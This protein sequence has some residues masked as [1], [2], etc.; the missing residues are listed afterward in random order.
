MRQSSRSDWRHVRTVGSRGPASRWRRAGT[1]AG[2]FALAA[3]A[4]LSATP[5]GAELSGVGFTS[6]LEGGTNGC[7]LSAGGTLY[8]WGSNSHDQLLEANPSETAPVALDLSA[9]LG[10]NSIT[11]YAT[12]NGTTCVLSSASAVYC[13]GYNGQGELGDGS[14]GGT[15]PA[16]PVRVSFSG[17]QSGTITQLVG[18]GDKTFCA[19]TST[20]QIWCWG[21]G[22]QGQLG[23]DASPTNADSPVQVYTGGVLSGR[24]I[25]SISGTTDV[26]CA[27]DTG[28]GAYCW[29]DNSDDALG[30]GSSASTTQPV[31]V[32][33]AAFPLGDKVHAIAP[34][35][36][37][38]CLVDTNHAVWCWG[39]NIGGVN[40]LGDPDGTGDAN[41]WFAVPQ[42]V[43]TGTSALTGVSASS[44]VSSNTESCGLSAAGALYCWGADPIGDGGSDADVLSPEAITGGDIVGRTLVRVSAASYATCAIDSQSSLYCW[45][46]NNSGEIGDGSTV[47]SVTAEEIAASPSAT[48][49]ASVPNT[50]REVA[51]EP[52]NDSMDVTWSAPYSN[53]GSSVTGFTA[54]ATTLDGQQSF[55]C[56]AGA[57]DTGCTIDGLANGTSYDLSVVA[58]N[59]HGD[60]VP[61]SAGVVTLHTVP[62]APSLESVS[63]ASGEIIVTWLEGG[64]DGGLSVESFTATATTSTTSQ[65]CQG[66]PDAT[67]CTIEGLVD[68]T[69]YDVSV[70]AT[71][72]DGNSMPSNTLSAT[73]GTVS[74]APQGV[75]ASAGPASVQVSWSAPASDGDTPI[76]GYVAT[77]T[78]QRTSARAECDVDAAATG[79]EIDGLTNGDAYVVVVL[80]Q[81]QAGNS[82]PASVPG[83]YTP[84]SVPD[85]PTLVSASGGDGTITVDWSAGTSDGGTPVTS[86]TASAAIGARTVTCDGGASATSCT[87]DGLDNGTA[88]SVWVIATNAKG[89]SAL[90]STL[91]ATPYTTPGAPTITKVTPAAGSV[92]LAWSAPAS[93][94]GSPIVH[95]AVTLSPGSGGCVTTALTCT[96]SHLVATTAYTF[97]LVAVN[98]AGSGAAASTGALYAFGGKSLSLAVANAVQSPSVSFTVVV[99]GGPVGATVTMV[100]T[101]TRC[102]LDA[103]GQ[104]TFS[105]RATKPG[106]YR[107][108]AHEGTVNA[109]LY[110]YLPVVTVPATAVH[111]KATELHVLDCPPGVL[112]KVT[113][114]NGKSF[115]TKTNVG[116]AGAVSMVFAKAG[117]YTLTTTVNG[118]LV[119]PTHTIKVT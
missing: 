47:S 18:G 114:S 28:G 72:A 70:E 14:F 76:T 40:G 59:I 52:G 115:T 63:V 31:A 22:S 73:P 100:G 25:A 106:A 96:I 86:F 105:V 79:C 89:P 51:G 83:T 78:D 11:G 67:S 8:C 30:D 69:A 77:A 93:S 64:Y 39:S 3:L 108:V 45:G 65:G 34:S 6:V 66:A 60:S 29:G 55:H 117:T 118:V 4:S 92:T 94:G 5:A 113:A 12:G 2:A 27:V 75:A 103:Y 44:I 1:V 57:S 116:G 15:P 98:A 43:S 26:F 24:V 21:G 109:T 74:S 10:A 97:T 17:A 49:I 42:L 87:I 50:P 61:A 112:V 95:Y 7:A 35:Q 110:Y 88:Y 71:N 56:T 85:A 90:S 48:T 99:G 19:L 46:E 32:D 111:A 101:T 119:K 53:G 104:C 81:N 20:S 38:S 107:V 54:T 13:W 82:P 58:T 37:H 68:G 84:L 23:N 80:A 33:L 62:D 102:T 41:S 36:T 16:D 9:T 91:M